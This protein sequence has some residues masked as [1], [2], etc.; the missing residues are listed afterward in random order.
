MVNDTCKPASCRRGVEPG[1]GHLAIKAIRRLIARV[2]A[3]P[4]GYKVPAINGFGRHEACR[5]GVVIE[6]KP[7]ILSRS[8]SD[9]I[10]I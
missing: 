5:I 10:R 1:E 3:R 9:L 7:R 8:R 6:K 2:K 4:I